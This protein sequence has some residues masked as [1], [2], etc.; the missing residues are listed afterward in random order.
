V[1]PTT[2]VAAL[3][4]SQ[5]PK[6]RSLKAAPAANRPSSVAVRMASLRHLDPISRVVVVQDQSS[7]AVLMELRFEIMSRLITMCSVSYRSV[8]HHSCSSSYDGLKLCD[9]LDASKDVQLRAVL[10]EN[11]RGPLDASKDVQLRVV[12][13]EYT[14][15]PLDATKDVGPIEGC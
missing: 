5:W 4:G 14:R 6:A 8:L 10:E 15:G 12:L 3:M 13:E 11:T 2:S 7:D 1:R 9:P